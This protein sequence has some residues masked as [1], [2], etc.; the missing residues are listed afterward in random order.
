LRSGRLSS[1]LQQSALTD[2]E[3]WRV[4]MPATRRDVSIV[5]RRAHMEGNA[6]PSIARR[7]GRQA[8][9][10]SEEAW[11]RA[12]PVAAAFWAV[13]K[14]VLKRALEFLLAL[15]IVFEE[16][17]WRPLADLLGRLGRWR[18]WA[19]VETAI[20]RLPPYA[21]LVVFALP[22]LLLLPLK[23]VALFLVANGQVVLAGLLFI[24]AKVV[25]TALIARLFMLTQPALMQIG[26]FASAHDT[27]MPWKEALVAGVHASW[28][29]RAGRIWKERARRIAGAQWQ[30]WRPTM[31]ELKA[32]LATWAYAVRRSGRRVLLD[33]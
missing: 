17:G 10:R 22:T 3:A 31:L 2:I 14:P 33:I 27:V 6:R 12:H 8:R 9:L 15:V 29:W 28:P 5:P 13:A 32:A 25:A 24:A 30:R 21:A 1:H 18:L 4:T 19:A 11:R 23:F 26:W 20:I 16:W 7:L